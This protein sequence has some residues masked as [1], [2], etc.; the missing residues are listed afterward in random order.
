[1]K[2]LK[3]AQH[4]VSIAAV[5]LSDDLIQ[6]PALVQIQLRHLLWCEPCTLQGIQDPVL[7]LYQ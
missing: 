2:H 7:A 3:L 1:M 5:Q 6:E 4:D